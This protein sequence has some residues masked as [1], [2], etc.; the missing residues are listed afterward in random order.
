MMEVT[1]VIERLKELGGVTSLSFSE[2][3]EV[4]GLYHDVLDKTFVRTSCNDCYRDAIIEMSVY[5]KKHGK[6]KEKRAYKLKSGVLL[7]MEFGSP[8]FYTNENLT[9]DIAEEYLKKYPDNVG[10]FAELPE[11]WEERIV[12]KA[13][14]EKLLEEIVQAKKDGISDESIINEL[15]SSRVNGKRVTKA[16][17]K[18]YIE[19]AKRLIEETNEE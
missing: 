9:D 3:A 13:F 19:E 14:D 5:L 1:E 6:M 18:E 11:D 12:G 16:L 15:A 4:E 10:Y 2:K 7:Q 17:L 8:D